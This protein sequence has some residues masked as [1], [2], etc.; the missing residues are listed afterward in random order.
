MRDFAKKLL[1]GFVFLTSL[2]VFSQAT[3][4]GVIVDADLN[5]PLAGANVVV[6][7]TTDG[8]TT[9]FDG[10]FEFTT[11]EK[12]GQIV[13][14]Y[15]G[16]E[17]KV[18]SFTVSGN[19]VNLGNVTLTPDENQLEG[20][21]VVGSGVIDLAK[22]RKTPIAVSTIKAAEIQAKIGTADVTQAL[23]NTPSV[24]VAGQ[25]GGYGDSRMTVRGFQQDNTAFLLNGQPING[26]EDGKMY[27]SN[28]SGMSDIANVIQIQ[29]GL[30]SSKLAISSVGGTVNFVTKATE[31]KQGGFASMG[32]A[33]SDYFKSTVGY[34]TGMSK[35]GWGFSVMMSHWQGDGYNMGTRGEGQNY[36]ISLGYKPS[37]KHNFNFLLTGAP[38]YHDQNFTKSISTY[39]QYGRKYN[40]NYGYLN[41]QYLSER[42]NF[43]HKPVANL[44]WDFN[45]NETTQLSTVLYA[46]WGRGGG[47]GNYGTRLRT[48]DGL[49][50][51]DTMYANNLATANG[52]GSYSNGNY[53]IR[54]SMNNH[55][56]YG[57]V[58]NLKKKINENLSFNAGMDLRTYYGTHYRQ[59]ANFLGLNSWTE[60]RNLKGQN[61]LPTGTIVSNTVTDYGIAKPWEAMFNTVGES[62]R[63]DYDYSERISYGGVFGQV[64]YATE[65]VSAFF[66]GS[67][68]E[69]M[70]QRFDR[71]DYLP[72]YKDAKK[73]DNFGFNTKGGVAYNITGQHTVFVNAGYYSRQ[74]YHDNIY[75]NYTNA[76]NPLTE[77]EKILGL[78]AG[79]TFTSSIFTANLNVYRTSW[80]DR[81]TTT[82]TVL[83][84]DG[85]IGTTPVSTGDLIYTTSQNDEQLHTGA[86]VDFTLKP[87]KT[88]SV[89]GFASVGNWE[90][91]GNAVQRKY[92]EGLDVL[93][94]SKVDIEGGKVGDAA[95]TTWGL[96]AKYEIFE[97]FSIDADWRN[98]DKLYA[99][100]SARKENIELP[101]YD[102]VDAGISYKMLVGKDKKNSVGFRFNMNNVFNEVYLS[103]LTTANKVQAGD[104]TWNGINVSNAGYF[105]LGRTWNFSI[106]Y[107]F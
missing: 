76:V 87:I 103:E 31:K 79:Y 9:D 78:E 5:E 100:V 61:D 106:R 70:H 71:Y 99:N 10:K 12:S 57:M 88:L 84:A 17:S 29:R 8:A 94:E 41:G 93:D 74:P 19:T 82:S 34:N 7:G 98:Y 24:Y 54:A 3:V 92:N 64:E 21:V 39:L 91:R 85:T 22:D 11:S 36:F 86:E 28:W 16:F 26:M 35:K 1:F 30:G 72:E 6:K 43:Y 20:V 55:A 75:L 44:N 56:W 77:N 95:Q 52:E 68:S 13:V 101:S 80:K 15:L 102:L 62:Q 104:E 46:S 48:A 89:K 32:V 50:D 105:G 58:T 25:S 81:V 51:F 66:Q 2:T 90:Y 40:N 60:S 107:N 97:R 4:T 18:I 96:G 83:T 47:T 27:W 65:K 73:V 14:S 37:D 23:V 53:L 67:V 69:Q 49:V 59:V 45:I 38:Q 33:N 42:T 63:I